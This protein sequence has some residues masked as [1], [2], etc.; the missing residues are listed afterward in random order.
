MWAFMKAG[1]G[2]LELQRYCVHAEKPSSADSGA[3]AGASDVAEQRLLASQSQELATM[4]SKRSEDSCSVQDRLLT[5]A[6]CH[7]PLPGLSTTS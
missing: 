3:G 7:C 2:L 5:A 6:Q 1:T 4:Q